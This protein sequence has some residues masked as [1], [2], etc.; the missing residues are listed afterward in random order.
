MEQS[1]LLKQW[2]DRYLAENHC[3][4]PSAN[5]L[6]GNKTKSSVLGVFDRS[7]VINCVIVA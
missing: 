1:G 6:L 4:V 7:A 2:A 5:I 3:M